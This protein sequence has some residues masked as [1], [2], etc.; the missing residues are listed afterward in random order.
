[1]AAE[2]LSLFPQPM[3]CERCGR[4]A[5]L[6]WVEMPC[7]HIYCPQRWKREC[8]ALERAKQSAFRQEYLSQEDLDRIA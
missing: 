3:G 5:T 4:P 2:Q 6:E 8:E 1:M 7:V